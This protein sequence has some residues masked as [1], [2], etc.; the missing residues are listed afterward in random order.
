MSGLICRG[1]DRP[2]DVSRAGREDL[3]TFKPVAFVALNE[4]QAVAVVGVPDTKQ[5]S[6]AYFLA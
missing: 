3:S 6:L 4:P 2:F 5:H 1:Y